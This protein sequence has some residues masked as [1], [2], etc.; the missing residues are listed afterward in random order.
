[1][2]F[3]SVIGGSE[4]KQQA[5]V[6]SAKKDYLKKAA[7]AIGLGAAGTVL[8]TLGGKLAI[9]NGKELGQRAWQFVEKWGLK[10][11]SI[12]DFTGLRA[13][14]FWGV[15]GYAG[16]MHASRDKHE[17]KETLVKFAAFVFSFLVPQK[18]LGK[19][20]AN[21]FKNLLGE[22]VEA[23]HKNITQKLSGEA[24]Q[25]AL[26]HWRNKNLLGLASSIVLLGTLPLLLNIYLTK[27]R[28]QK[29]E[30]PTNSTPPLPAGNLQIKPFEQWGQR[31]VT[32]QFQNVIPAKAGTR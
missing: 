18:L 30:A 16:W 11:G 4:N 17:R 21:K 29:T 5:D 23:T 8:A 25:T 27:K 28:M 12:N 24:Q 20:Y 22:G 31:P 19:S 13:V 14:L 10:N 7:I 26:K 3:A 15:P 1:M 9:K 2:E 32:G 6:E